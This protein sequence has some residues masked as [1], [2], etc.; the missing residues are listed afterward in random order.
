MTVHVLPHLGRRQL[1]Y[2]KRMDVEAWVGKLDQDGIKPA[3]V[4]A[5]H[6]VLRH[7]LQSAMDAG[8]IGRNPALGVKTAPE[9]QSKVVAI[10]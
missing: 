1:A 3:N 6:A 10:R 7:V 5:A 2:L 9:G 4:K 8:V